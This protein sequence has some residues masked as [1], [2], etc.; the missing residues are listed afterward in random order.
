VSSD[1]SPFNSFLIDRES[2]DALDLEIGDVQ[3]DG[4]VVKVR[5][6]IHLR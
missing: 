1:F 5:S 2:L 3:V 6:S 4:S